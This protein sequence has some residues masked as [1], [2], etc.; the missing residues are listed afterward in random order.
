[1]TAPALIVVGV[2]MARGLGEVDWTRIEFAIPV[3]L[4]VITMPLTYSVATGIA[5]GLFFYPLTMVARGRW[6]EV[7]PVGYVLFAVVVAFFIWL[8]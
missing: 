2:L 5:V 7:H 3:F 4:A 1:M 6:R 8:A